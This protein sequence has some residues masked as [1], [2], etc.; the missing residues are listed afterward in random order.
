MPLIP[1]A[2]TDWVVGGLRALAD[3]RP[4]SQSPVEDSERRERECKFGAW[5][6]EG[7]GLGDTVGRGILDA[8]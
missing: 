4:R 1:S 7:I 8:D 2:R 3:D 5:I 6:L